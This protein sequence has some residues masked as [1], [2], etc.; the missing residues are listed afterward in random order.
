M[1]VVIEKHFN[2]FH[3]YSLSFPYI[4]KWKP[5]LHS[6][7]SWKPNKPMHRIWLLSTAASVIYFNLCFFSFAHFAENYYSQKLYVHLVFHIFF[8]VTAWN[9]GNHQLFFLRYKQQIAQLGNGLVSFC[10]NLEKREFL[11]K[12]SVAR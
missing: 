8:L 9:M 11:F 6:T 1:Q 3:S 2:F 5:G 7:Y 10:D 4:L 12:L